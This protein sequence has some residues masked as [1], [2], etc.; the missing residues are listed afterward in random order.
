MYDALHDGSYLANA[1]LA[2]AFMASGQSMVP[3]GGGGPVLTDGSATSCADATCA[4][5]KGIG[6]RCG[7]GPK[8]CC[9]RD[10]YCRQ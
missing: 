6:F 3:A 7:N 9:C 4:Q 8:L 1:Q 2:A 5:F 10:S